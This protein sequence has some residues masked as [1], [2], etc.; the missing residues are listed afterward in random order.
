MSVVY[1]FLQFFVFQA[2]C[3]P[4]IEILELNRT[5]IIPFLVR[6]V[7]SMLQ[8]SVGPRQIHPAGDP[9]LFVLELLV[10]DHMGS[11]PSLGTV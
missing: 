3:V 11:L 8:Q 1:I 10:R 5:N 2:F 9:S 4:N 7:S 6:T